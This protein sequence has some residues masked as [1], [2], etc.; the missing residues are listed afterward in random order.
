MKVYYWSP[1]IS[2]VATVTSVINS[3]KAINKFSKKNIEVSIINVF[4]EWS[5]YNDIIIKNKIKILK[6]NIFLD[7][8]NLPKGSF[9]KSRLTY[10]ITFIFSI[11]KLD[12]LLKV[13]KPDFLIIHLITFIPLLLMVIFSYKTK[14]ILRISGFPKLNFFRKILWKLSNKKIYKIFCPTELTKE[15]LIKNNIFDIEKIFVVKDPII[16]VNEFKIKKNDIIDKSSIY[17]QEYIISIGRL[18]KQKN[19]L[20]LVNAFKH[21]L[22]KLPN[23]NLVI[24]G[25]GEDRFKIQKKINDNFLNGKIILAGEKKNIYP[26]LNKAVFF[27][28]TSDWEDPG[29]VILESMFSRKIVLSSDCMSGP[30]SIIN[31]GQNGFLYKRNN[32]YDFCEKFFFIYKNIINNNEEFKEI[33]FE[34]MKETKSYT[35]LHHF[36]LMKIHLKI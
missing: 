4:K 36:N 22:L 26:Y 35:L 23:I 10:F 9:F 14:F 15:I 2:H 28:L 34:A 32:L 11:F 29:F 27:V 1:F 6:L 8:K 3:V 16:D 30:V 24:L 5:P 18:T 12:K 33:L 25:E 19:F 7:I 13:E 31:N 17:N 20:F 21:V